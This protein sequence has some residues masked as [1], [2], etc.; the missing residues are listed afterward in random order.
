MCV[1]IIFIKN[2]CLIADGLTRKGCNMTETQRIETLSNE[3][4]MS[5][6]NY[7]RNVIDGIIPVSWGMYELNTLES[8]LREMDRRDGA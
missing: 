8:L 5:E 7:T 4:L 3:D 1:C 2:A 6:Y